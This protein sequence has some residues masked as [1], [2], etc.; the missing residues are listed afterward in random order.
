VSENN[1]ENIKAGRVEWIDLC[2]FIG[3]FYMVWAH[4]GDS[5]LVDKYIHIFHM[6]IFFFLSGYVFKISS[7]VRYREFILKRVKSILVPYFAFAFIVYYAWWSY[8][9]IIQQTIPVKISVLFYSTFS[10]NTIRSPFSGV[11]W[12]LTCLFLVE[13]MFFVIL[14]TLKPSNQG[15]AIIIVLFSIL[16]YFFGKLTDVRLFWGLD[17]AFTAIVFFGM[18]YLIKNTK[19]YKIKNKLNLSDIKMILLLLIVSLG[20]GLINSTVN[21]RTIKYGNYFLFYLSATASI[22]MYI[23]V[24]KYIGNSKLKATKLYKYC[25]YL[26]Q[27]SIVV[28]LLNQLYIQ[29]LK[30]LPISKL[31]GIDINVN[32]LG[33]IY[34][35]IVLIL[36]L[37]TIYMLNRYIPAIIGRKKLKKNIKLSYVNK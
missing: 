37:P 23:A 8:Y 20:T 36:M 24:S 27:N 1:Q 31:I 14:K 5:I 11:Q 19:S 13:I 17:T 3:I 28:L 22:F 21:L 18:G 2:K 16:G 4:S 6:P 34:S 33:L 7:S 10:C 29:M 9:Q 26:G 15:I 32:I 30:K 35:V 25:L 12:F